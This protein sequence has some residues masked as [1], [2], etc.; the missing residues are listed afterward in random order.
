ML[1]KTS[2]L[3]RAPPW[4]SAA[5]PRRSHIGRSSLLTGP[6]G[7]GKTTLAHV[8]ARQAGYEVLEI[9]AAIDRGRDVVKGRIRTS[10]GTE[11]VKTVEHKKP[12]PGKQPK[13]ARPICVVVDEVDGVVTGSGGS[14]RG[15]FIK[16]LIDL[17]LLD[18]ANGSG[19]DADPS[20]RRK[21]KATTSAR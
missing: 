3:F 19:V 15:G 18:Q 7:L 13:V 9:N 6:P 10:L 14:G 12:E 1:Q 5:G 11:S 4:K 20:R 2:P 16:A 21:K 17:V 8:C